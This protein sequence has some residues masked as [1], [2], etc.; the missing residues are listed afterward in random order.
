MLAAATFLLE[1]IVKTRGERKG[2]GD[3]PV[4]F[5]GRLKKFNVILHANNINGLCGQ[6]NE[7]HPCEKEVHMLYI[8]IYY[9]LDD[10]MRLCWCI[11]WCWGTMFSSQ[12]RI[13]IFFCPSLFA[14]VVLFAFLVLFHV[15]FCP[16]ASVVVSHYSLM[17]PST[18]FISIKLL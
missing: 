10:A 11:V 3:V 12:V 8:Y 13:I 14:P 1:Q 16:F 18:F 17:E 7:E 4:H 5:P 15:F 2:E 9:R 6:T